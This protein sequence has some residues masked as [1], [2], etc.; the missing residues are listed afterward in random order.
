[1]LKFFR[2]GEAA[3]RAAASRRT[4]A[5]AG[6]RGLIAGAAALAGLG[7]APATALTINVSQSS[8]PLTVA[9][10]TNSAGSGTLLALAQAAANVWEA[11]LDDGGAGTV[12][13]ISVG[14]ANISGL[15][16]TT[17]STSPSAGPGTVG[18]TNVKQVLLN[19][20]AT[21]DWYL[22]PTPFDMTGEYS[23]TATLD[24]TG[25]GAGGVLETGR[26][27]GSATGDA[28]GR[29]DA[30]TVLVHEIAHAVGFGDYA[31]S[32]FDLGEVDVVQP[33]TDD[34]FTIPLTNKGGGH[35]GEF[36][37]S[38]NAVLTSDYMN[39]LLYPFASPSRRV[40]PSEADVLVVAEIVGYI[41]GDSR[42]GMSLSNG[43]FGAA[44][45]LPAAGGLLAAGLLAMAAA[46]R[47]RRA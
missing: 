18:R 2:G 32:P 31:S 26:R 13:N 27:H 40:L 21:Y 28:A 24:T 6:A 38:G 43:T 23:G 1:M 11:A 46:G 42:V 5:G 39:A 41:L 12:I 3:S 10:P 30:F 29:Y 20:D 8:S 44:V 16:A 33:G 22:D 35:V 45:P 15:G 37:G 25:D 14:W 34:V 4:S 9:G 17:S 47:R 7:A 36:D 19:A